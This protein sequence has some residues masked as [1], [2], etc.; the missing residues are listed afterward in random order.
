MTII[1]A[2]A[3]SPTIGQPISSREAII[4]ERNDSDVESVDPVALLEGAAM[5]V[6]LDSPHSPPSGLVAITLHQYLVPY[7]S[8]PVYL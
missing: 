8:M 3:I 2:P 1:T 4:D 6:K 5:V 7:S